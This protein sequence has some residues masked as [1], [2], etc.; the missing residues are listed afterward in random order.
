MAVDN[1]KKK[2]SHKKRETI[3][4]FGDEE[5]TNVKIKKKYTLKSADIDDEKNGKK[6]SLENLKSQINSLNYAVGWEEPL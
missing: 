6:K 3:S 5:T 2:K 1:R 4:Y